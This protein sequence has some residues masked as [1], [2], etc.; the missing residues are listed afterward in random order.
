MKSNKLEYAF[1]LSDRRGLDIRSI[2]IRETDA[3]DERN[4]RLNV[5]AKG[6]TATFDEELINF[7]IVEVDDVRVSQPYTGM[8]GWNTRTRQTVAALFSGIN[9]GEDVGPLIQAGTPRLTSSTSTTGAAGASS[10]G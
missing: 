5:K 6:P 9:S 1:D 8:Q 7:S 2:V 10:S 3:N 4:A